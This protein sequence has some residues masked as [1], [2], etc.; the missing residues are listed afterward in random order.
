MNFYIISFEVVK[1]EH[2]R[3]LKIFFTITGTF[4]FLH[5]ASIL[6]F[7]ISP[8]IFYYRAWEY[9]TDIGYRELGS[10]IEWRGEEA[11]DLSRGNLI[12][13]RQSW[14]TTVTTDEHGFRS[15]AKLVDSY[16]IV[17]SGDSSIYGSGLSDQDTLPW[18]LSKILDV[19][20]FNGGRTNTPN[21]LRHP[22]TY[23]VDV[24]IEAMTERVITPGKL[25]QENETLLTSGEVFAPLAHK[26]DT[27]LEILRD[28][29]VRRYSLPLIGM[30]SLRRLL[31]DA[32][33]FLRGENAKP[34]L[35]LR[36]THRRE[37][38][39]RIVDL[40]TERRDIIA[41]RVGRYVFLAIPAKQ[42]IYAD[43]VDPYTKDFIP[44]LVAALRENGVEAIDLTATFRRESDDGLYFPYDTH[45]NATGAAIAAQEI[46]RQVFGKGNNTPKP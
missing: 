45:W 31:A 23:A 26:T 44:T 3:Y 2:A 42:T 33:N 17:V 37:N 8:E 10:P 21:A 20:V 1:M 9:F 32:R 5:V 11:G 35:F 39:E 7:L 41:N 22:R 12:S 38:L 40:I 30:N 43:D 18:R 34:R 16:P 36:H 24:V 19:P 46:A 29:P 15:N 28:L 6:I 27:R 14:P 13:Y 25:E 4:A